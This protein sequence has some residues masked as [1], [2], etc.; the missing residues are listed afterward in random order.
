VGAVVAVGVLWWL[1]RGAGAGPNAP[2]VPLVDITNANGAPPL[3]AAPRHPAEEECR[4]LGRMYTL[5]VPAEEFAPVVDALRA[6]GQAA[7]VYGAGIVQERRPLPAAPPPP[8]DLT[9]EELQLWNSLHGLGIQPATVVDAMRR[10]RRRQ[11][12]PAA[13]AQVEREPQPPPLL[14]NGL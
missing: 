3:P 1:R 11:A 4:L 12:V 14:P 6:R 13:G 8:E 10:R 9:N 5:N 7:P 2:D